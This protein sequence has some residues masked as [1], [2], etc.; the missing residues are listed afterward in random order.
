MSDEAD[1]LGMIG[2]D[3]VRRARAIDINEARDVVARYV[4]PKERWALVDALNLFDRLREPGGYI[5]IVG[6]GSEPTFH[7]LRHYVRLP[8]L[9]SWAM[10]ASTLGG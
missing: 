6:F 3:W 7:T 10:K 5:D 1:P 9:D 4:P 2:D 8:E